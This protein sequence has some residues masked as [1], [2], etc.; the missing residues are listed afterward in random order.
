MSASNP[1]STPAS[2]PAPTT[3]SVL[4]S[5][6]DD[7]AAAVAKASHSLVAI[8]ARRRIPSTGVIWRPGIVVTAHHTIQ[9][10]ERITVTLADG[11]SVGATLAGRDPTTDIAVLRLNSEVGVPIERAATGAARVG[12]LVLALG[13]PGPAVTAAL[14]VVAPPAASG[15]A[16]GTVDASTS[17]SA[18]T[19]PS[20]TASRAARRSMPAGEWSGST[21]RDSRAPRP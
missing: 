18:S 12:Q 17:S 2:T 11:T 5:L 8:H 21:P 19:S 4:Q 9:R 6:S 20:T 3:P 7:L 14:G 13:M 10:E 16:P 1:A 15:A